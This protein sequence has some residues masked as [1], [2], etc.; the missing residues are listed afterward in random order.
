MYSVDV[1]HKCVEL[2]IKKYVVLKE[3]LSKS[4]SLFFK[5]KNRTTKAL[6]RIV[7]T[8]KAMICSSKQ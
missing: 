2:S 6:W 3:S 8:I 4:P 1:D 7:L 5:F